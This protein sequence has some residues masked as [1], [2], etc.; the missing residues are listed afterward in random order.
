MLGT[1][2]MCSCSTESSSNVPV[3]E[4]AP[5]EIP[6]PVSILVPVEIPVVIE[7]PIPAEI[8]MPV[9]EPVV[10]DLPKGKVVTTS[11]NQTLTT[12]VVGFPTV[13]EGFGLH[14]AT[15]TLVDVYPGWSGSAP[16]T[17]VNGNDYARTFHLMLQQPGA[18]VQNGYEPFPEGC[19]SWITLEDMQPK[20]AI[21][22][23]RKV[24]VTLSAPFNFPAEMRG[25]KYDVRIL[26]EDWSQTGFIQLALQQKWLITF[27]DGKS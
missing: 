21:G 10:V 27:W 9:S 18:T 7:V 2:V 11:S 15:V 20:V 3:S 8:P 5:V 1:L 25:K 26:V 12:N 23:V 6:T 16:I 22:G 24:S 19:F 13:G 17:I 4:P 14:G